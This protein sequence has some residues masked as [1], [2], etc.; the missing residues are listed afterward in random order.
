MTIAPW[1]DPERTSK[2][3][4]T[5]E[6][7]SSALA[8]A[9]ADFELSQRLRARAQSRSSPKRRRGRPPAS[10]TRPAQDDG[11]GDLLTVAE[12]CSLLAEG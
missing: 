8:T 3:L 7:F 5:D 10:H 9:L 1:L 2:P 4:L 6:Q 12:V 11:A